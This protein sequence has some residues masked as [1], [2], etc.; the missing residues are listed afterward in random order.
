MMIRRAPQIRMCL[1]ISL[2]VC[3]FPWA[4]A[5]RSSAASG[6]L[7]NQ[8]A[9]TPKR[10]ASGM[11][12]YIIKASRNQP[13]PKAPSPSE[14]LR[15]F[16][17]DGD[18]ILLDEADLGIINGM[19]TTNITFRDA[20][21]FRGLYAPP[22]ASSDFVL[23]GRVGGETV[24][25]GTYT[26]YPF[27]VERQGEVEGV[28][29]S[30]SIV[31]CAG[32]RAALLAM[33][34]ENR[35]SEEKRLPLQFTIR[36][37]LDYVREWEFGKPNAVKETAV[38][39][40]KNRLVKQNDAGAIVIGA[41]FP[42][43]RWEPWSSHWETQVRLKPREK[44]THYLCVTI[45][46]PVAAAG[47]CRAALADPE[48]M[49]QGARRQWAERVAGLFARLPRLEA[50]D[51]RLE[52]Y[53]NRSLLH[54]LLNQWQ[55]PEFL[56]HPY[57]STGSINGGC[58]CSYLWD[59]GEAWEVLPLY[60]PAADRE[61]IKRFLSIDLTS[62][63]AFS[64]ITGEAFGPWYPVNQEKIIRSIYY[65][66][67]LTGDAAFLKDTVGGKTILDWVIYQ[68]MVGDDLSRP[69]ALIDYGNGNHHLELRGK[70]R[71]DNYLPDLN[72]RRYDNYVAAYHLSVLGGQPAPYLLERAAALKRLLRDAMWNPEHKW[73]FH[74]APDLTKQLRYTI[75][76]FKLIGS[77]VLDREEEEGLLS[78]INEREFLSAYG[79]HSM[80]KLD[81]AYDQTDIDNGGGG[82]YVSFPPQIAERLYRAGHPDLA[83]DI[84]QRILWLGERLPYWGDSQVANAMDYRRDTPLQCS[85]GAVA[86]AQA[87][88]FGMFG[89]S[90]TPDG[91]IT[92]NPQP[93]PWSPEISLS[94]LTI[95]G[96]TMDIRANRRSYEVIAN[97]QVIRSR[98][99]AAV[100]LQASR[101]AR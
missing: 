60:D 88:I 80:S 4:Q 18:A 46:D 57:Y 28:R 90:V 7:T 12:M 58:V 9:L 67:L 49:M 87:V 86:G 96:C 13:A 52:A 81:E 37:G 40:E 78:H 42:R 3:T 29:M 75:Q 74:L 94:G 97:G 93:P 92:V 95:R 21:S 43:L 17:M 56:L 38:A 19:F 14:S 44:Q 98:R 54:L 45:G 10:G 71:Y 76:M 50:S 64:P 63:F 89:V 33:T 26:W 2:L 99:G 51:K 20:L 72:G 53:Y 84:M 36:G 69:V 31:L 62:H 66:I 73:F 30:S 5:E 32:K 24:A 101:S 91:D 100:M 22:Y 47:D 11:R 25:T 16:A 27:A 82:S 41:D 65:Y 55:V 59:F 35:T 61:H 1:F 68:A 85:I 8:A 39:G 79:M 83:A 48:R 15:V 6:R 23:E 77:D 34:F 70:Y